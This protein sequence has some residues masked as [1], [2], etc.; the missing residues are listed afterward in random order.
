MF[1]QKLEGQNWG[2][3]YAAALSERQARPTSSTCRWLDVSGIKQRVDLARPSTDPPLKRASGRTA[4]CVSKHPYPLLC[5]RRR[6]CQDLW[7][8][9]AS[10][11][12]FCFSKPP[13]ERDRVSEFSLWLLRCSGC[14]KNAKA[15]NE[16]QQCCG[17]S[18]RQV[19]S[20]RMSRT[21]GRMPGISR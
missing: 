4:A 8:V 16:R 21:T 9:P 20:G 14:R 12:G 17:S 19:T 1:Q 7:T 3:R 2:G 10:S 5:S 13:D 11:N 18:S 15:E 6:R